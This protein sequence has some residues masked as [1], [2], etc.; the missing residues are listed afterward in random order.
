MLPTLAV[1]VGNKEKQH[2]S[3]SSRIVFVKRS[4]EKRSERELDLLKNPKKDK[5]ARAGAVPI[6]I[7]PDGRV[8]RDSWEIA[9]STGLKDIAPEFKQILDTELG[10]LARQFAYGYILHIRNRNVWNRLVCENNHWLWVVVWKYLGGCKYLTDLMS[11]MF[12]PYDEV[13]VKECKEKL[14]ALI[15]TLSARVDRRQGKYLDGDTLG[16]ADIAL[17]SLMAPVVFPTKYCGGKYAAI[18]DTLQ[19]QDAQMRSE[20]EVFRATSAGRYTMQI[21]EEYR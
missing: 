17:V 18:F 9:S 7:Y 13:A 10:P 16:V 21:Y 12:R 2:L 14:S 1:R 3:E 8:L 4:D 6:A 20:I 11:K 15:G 19:A 5:K